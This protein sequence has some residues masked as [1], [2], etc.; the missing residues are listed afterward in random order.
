MIRDNLSTVQCETK[1]FCFATLAKHSS[2]FLTK[3]RFIKFTEIGFHV[4]HSSVLYKQ[5][6]ILDQEM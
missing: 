6:L 1:S 4:I 3:K 5:N 2:F